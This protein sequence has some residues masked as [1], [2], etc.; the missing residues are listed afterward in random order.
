MFRYLVLTGFLLLGTSAFAAEFQA[1]DGAVIVNE[2]QAEGK[3]RIA[4]GRVRGVNQRWQFEQE[5]NIAG[6]AKATT[7]QLDDGVNYEDHVHYVQSWLQQADAH[8]VYQCQGR[9]C[10]AS[11]LWANNYFKDWRL[12]GPD[13][14][15]Y[16]WLNQ[17]GSGYQMLYLIERGSRKVY[18]HEKS[19]KTQA[20]AQQSQ[21]LSECDTDKIKHLSR[22]ASGLVLISS[23]KDEGQ[24]ASLKLAQQCRK[25]LLAAEVDSDVLA[26]GHYD[27][28]W[29]KVDAVQY[30]WVEIE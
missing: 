25:A 18:L 7:W 17:S 2:Q 22:S 10:G 20:N 5:D 4:K 29:H 8:I 28:H 13:D 21:Q 12:Y 9:S 3:F 14:N 15:Q 27:R 19:V 26:L 24:E 6:V 23:P 30:E 1:P 16:Y 11:N